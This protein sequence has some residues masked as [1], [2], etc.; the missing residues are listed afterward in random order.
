MAILWLG[1]E[2]CL[3]MRFPWLKS[4]YPAWVETIKVKSNCRMSIRRKKG[5]MRVGGWLAGD[6]ALVVLQ[7]ASQATWTED[8]P[9]G[10]SKINASD[11]GRKHCRAAPIPFS[12]LGSFLLL[13][14]ANHAAQCT[15]YW[16]WNPAGTEV[17]IKFWLLS[18]C[19]VHTFPYIAY[20]T[21]SSTRFGP[22]K[23]R[24]YSFCQN[25]SNKYH[26]TR[27]KFSDPSFPEQWC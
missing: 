13:A 9:G 19:Q 12:I 7:R 27:S 14:P 6:E 1:N 18:N 25:A 26:I 5:L 3:R 4:C 16:V 8:I 20:I 24:S 2:E 11:C 21:N 23:P 10:E 22:D 15:E 17:S